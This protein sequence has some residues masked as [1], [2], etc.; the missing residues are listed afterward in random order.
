MCIRDRIDTAYEFFD[1]Y[2]TVYKS[3]AVTCMSNKKMLRAITQKMEDVQ[4]SSRQKNAYIFMK[5]LI[6][7]STRQMIGLMNIFD[8]R[9]TDFIELAPSAGDDYLNALNQL[10][11]QIINIE[12][13]QQGNTYFTDIFLDQFEKL[14]EIAEDSEKDLLDLALEK[15]G[16]IFNSRE[17]ANSNN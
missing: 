11:L 16:E 17:E 5:S 8:E 12:D 14:Q 2:I 4:F 9:I 15:L 3:D 6:M 13:G 1:S 7:S 10:I